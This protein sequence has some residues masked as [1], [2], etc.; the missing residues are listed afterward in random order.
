LVV[1]VGSGDAEAA[2]SLAGYERV[3]R[4]Q[5]VGSGFRVFT[6]DAKAHPG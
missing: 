3:R 6:S 4:G 5:G 2:M 1:R